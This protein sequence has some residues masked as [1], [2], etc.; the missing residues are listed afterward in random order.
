MDSANV[1]FEGIAI[2][3]EWLTTQ[4]LYLE[5]IAQMTPT[6]RKALH[7][8]MTHLKTSFDLSRSNGFVEWRAQQGATPPYD[9]RVQQRAVAVAE[10]ASS[11]ESR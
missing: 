3:E 10:A 1:M 9:P 6:Q 8:A 5:Y 2:P 11:T 7:I 4:P